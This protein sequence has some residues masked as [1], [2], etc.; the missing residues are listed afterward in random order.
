MFQYFLF[1]KLFFDIIKIGKIHLPIAIY[2]TQN[3]KRI[4][5]EHFTK[6]VRI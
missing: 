1:F 6:F 2:K 4:R 5:L 3:F